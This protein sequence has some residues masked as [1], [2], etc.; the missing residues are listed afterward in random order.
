MAIASGSS[1]LGRYEATRTSLDGELHARDMQTPWFSIP[2]TKLGLKKEPKLMGMGTTN[3]QTL[4]L[5]TTR[6]TS[7]GT[8]ELGT[9]FS[10][11]SIPVFAGIPNAGSYRRSRENLP[12]TTAIYSAVY[13]MNWVC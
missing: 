1:T 2:L 6:S 7:I 13:C 12:G 9:D 10:D 5:K 3:N 4:N 11:Y 8:A